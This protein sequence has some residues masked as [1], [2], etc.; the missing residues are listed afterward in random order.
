MQNV[1]VLLTCVTKLLTEVTILLTY[2]AKL[3]TNVSIIHIGCN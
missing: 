1:T 2:V 3:L